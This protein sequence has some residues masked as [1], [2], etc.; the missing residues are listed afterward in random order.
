M[1]AHRGTLSFFGLLPQLLVSLD[2]TSHVL[3][4]KW[5]MTIHFLPAAPLFC[6]LQNWAIF[7]FI[8]LTEIFIWL[9][10]KMAN[11]N[12][13]ILRFYFVKGRYLEIG[14]LRFCL[15]LICIFVCGHVCCQC[16]IFSLTFG[17]IAEI[18]L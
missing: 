17:G 10:R 6:I 9:W 8:T 5:E 7:F 11:V 12:Y 15:H 18:S 2:K 1:N 14:P 13:T 4:G 3:T 16:E